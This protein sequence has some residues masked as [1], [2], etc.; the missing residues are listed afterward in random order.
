[1]MR[2]PR[3][4]AMRNKWPYVALPLL[5]IVIFILL[6]Q[7]SYLK[8]SNDILMQQLNEV[9]KSL[10]DAERQLTDIERKQKE[11]VDKLEQKI[12]DTAD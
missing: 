5:V 6:L 7:N 2:L 10:D 12:D 4:E 1:M 9:Q 8:G 11:N 3:R